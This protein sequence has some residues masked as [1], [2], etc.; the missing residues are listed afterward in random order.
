MFGWCS[1]E[2]IKKYTINVLNREFEVRIYDNYFDCKGFFLVKIWE[3]KKMFLQPPDIRFDTRENPISLIEDA[4]FGYISRQQ[5]YKD[6]LRQI[7]E[8]GNE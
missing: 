7:L 6:T 1:E 2:L 8:V 4:I 5:K 3:G